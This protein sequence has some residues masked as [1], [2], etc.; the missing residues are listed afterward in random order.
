M[1]VDFSADE[2]PDGERFIVE[3]PNVWQFYQGASD[4]DGATESMQFRLPPSLGRLVD[5][6]LQEGKEKG[7]PMRT[8]SDFARLAITVTLEA[9]T[10]FIN[11]NNEALNH[12]LLLIE[13]ASRTAHQTELMSDVRTQ[14]QSTVN[15]LSAM[16]SPNV[17]GYR[18]AKIRLTQFCAT[19]LALK[20]AGNEF[21]GNMY[22]K[23]VFNNRVMLHVITQI[24]ENLTEGAGIVIQS[25]RD[26]FERAK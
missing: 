5:V 19:I 10:R 22:L 17:K 8:R 21:L 12:E 14:V 24:E 26:E 7:V 11:S 18:E 1:A 2:F 9:F 25:A 15:G 4:K 3:I 6:A 23:E 20:N 13:Q 16:I